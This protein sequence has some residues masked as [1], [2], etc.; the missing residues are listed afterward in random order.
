MDTLAFEVSPPPLPKER[1]DEHLSARLAMA[2][3]QPLNGPH[4]SSPATGYRS[5]R[6][7]VALLRRAGP[8]DPI[9]VPE[10]PSRGTRQAPTPVAELG[11]QNTNHR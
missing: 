8:T 2:F 9:D 3:R 11:S 7:P 10:G 6:A 5:C 4:P 1:R